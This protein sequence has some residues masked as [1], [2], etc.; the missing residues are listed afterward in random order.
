MRILVVEDYLPTLNSIRKEL[1]ADGF[2]VDS[3]TDGMEGLWYAENNRYEVILLD[4][5]LP[6]L[7]GWSILDKLRTR[8]Q[9]THIIILTA[10]DS[11]DDRVHGLDLGA[12]DYLV[13]PFA[14]EELKARIRAVS[15]RRIG[16]KNPLV[17]LPN[18]L[19][20]D[21]TQRTVTLHG[22]TV[23]LTPREYALLFYLVSH[24]DTV[25]TRN[26]IWDGVY[27]FHSKA[28]SNVVDVYVARLRRKLHVEGQSPMI[29]T[30]RGAGY[31][32]DSTPQHTA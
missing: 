10:R 19:C 5:M 18:G 32:L 15:R 25:V 23:E 17:E 31:I 11:V 12:D 13:K 30:R 4:I 8:S 24:R 27:E 29:R 7:D 28:M 22:E 21:T 9:D 3:S 16:Q 2:Q 1:T 6:N 20:L 26:E 14:M